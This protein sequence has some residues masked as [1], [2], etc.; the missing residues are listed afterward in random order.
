MHNID[1]VL[2]AV[3]TYKRQNGLQ[4]LLDSL[5]GI[6]TTIRW[7]VVVVD[8]DRD[9]SAAPTVAEHPLNVR[10]EIEPDPGIS[11]ARNRCLDLIED[12]DD[13]LVFVDDDEL[14]SPSWLDELVRT[15]ENYDVDIVAAP[16]LALP[17]KQVPKWLTTGGFMHRRVRPTGDSSGIP[18]TGNV[19]IRTD[20]LRRLGSPRFDDSFSFTGGS[21]TD[22]FVRLLSQGASM[23][24]CAEAVVYEHVPLERTRLTWLARR[25]A[26]GGEV[27]ARI[28]LRTNNRAKI[29]LLGTA[30]CITAV[31]VA[32]ATVLLLHRYRGLNFILF[33]RGWGMLRF[34]RGQSYLE[35]ARG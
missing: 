11:A 10:Y 12:D 20:A 16:V 24:W 1:S 19:L 26:R 30:Y 7:R 6:E 25:Y 31:L 5:M 33:F 29:A 27:W 4:D 9:G 22:F 32:P 3:I 2:I 35:Y 28:A 34:L 18:A 23:V 17:P 8:N 14:V 21:D 15:A 13:A